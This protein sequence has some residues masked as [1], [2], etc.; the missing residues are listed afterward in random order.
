MLFQSLEH[1]DPVRE[2]LIAL[3]KHNS[4]NQPLF[5]WI[6]VTEDISVPPLAVIVQ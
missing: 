5:E 1:L 2:E 3:M 6:Q 4:D